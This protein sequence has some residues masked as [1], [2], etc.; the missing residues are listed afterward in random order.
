VKRLVD[1]GITTQQIVDIFSGENID[2]FGV[3]SASAQKGAGGL[4]SLRNALKDAGGTSEEVAR[5]MDDNLN[6]AI[7]N[8]QSAMEGFVIAVGEAGATDFLRGVLDQT[9]KSFQA[10]E[11][12]LKAV[13]A[14]TTN[15]DGTLTA[16]GVTLDIIIKVAAATAAVLAFELAMKGLAVA[17]GYVAI[18]A[19]VAWKAILSPLGLIGAGL[20]VGGALLEAFAQNFK[21]VR[22][23]ADALYGAIQGIVGGVLEMIGLKK[24]AE[25]EAT[26][27][28]V[29]ETTRLVNEYTA[30]MGRLGSASDETAKATLESFKQLKTPLQNLLDDQRQQLADLTKDREDAAARWV[31][32]NGAPIRGESGNLTNS[33]IGFEQTQ[34]DVDAQITAITGSVRKLE[35]TLSGSGLLEYQAQVGITFREN[36]KA[37]NAQ[38]KQQE[39][40]DAETQKAVDAVLLGLGERKRASA[41][42]LAQG[43]L[44]GQQLIQLNLLRET[45]EALRKAGIESEGAR[46]AILDGMLPTIEAIAVAENQRAE[47]NADKKIIDSLKGQNEEYRKLEE[48]VIR[49]R[50]ES[51]LTQGDVNAVLANSSYQ[52]GATELL[53]QL[54]P[55]EQAEAA[56]REALATNAALLAQFEQYLRDGTVKFADEQGVRNAIA[57]KLDQDLG[58]VLKAQKA[59]RDALDQSVGFGAAND[60]LLAGTLQQDLARIS[61]EEDTKRALLLEKY[62]T[63]VVDYQGYKDRLAAIDAE[64]GR[65]KKAAEIANAQVMLAAAQS[66]GESITGVLKET[67]GEQSVLY[68]ISFAAT[69]AFAIAQ[70]ILNIQTAL[71][72]AAASLPFPANLGAIATVAAETASIISTISSVALAMKD[73]GPVVGRGG[74]R[75]DMIP[76]MLSN[77]EFVI[78]AEAT[79]RNRAL[80]EAIN[81]NRRYADGGY[82]AMS[83]GGS[84][85]VYRGAGAAEV[86]VNNTF[87]IGAGASDTPE[88][89]RELLAQIDRQS[90]ASARM[91]IRE[92]MRANG[93][94][95]NVRG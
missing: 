41:A 74:P 45:D 60:P 53:S 93:M 79:K 48:R 19:G 81:G 32:L 33:G 44:E 87:N 61:L 47:N 91:A 57:A 25:L 20:A 55:K 78:N 65:R 11:G 63:G 16:L 75:D 23:V 71:S 92:E 12:A 6:G 13:S 22:A 35:A 69:K 84:G 66:T 31:E 58:A 95:A 10:F 5:I 67:L 26:N 39:A 76:A 43:D 88:R 73:G 38:R 50:D 40:L 42:L 64:S 62:N 68:K 80:L 49:L 56:K 37:A 15:T 1:A 72:S 77:G 18:A 30:A 52:K 82:V 83:T 8:A 51:K 9:A 36:E 70:S 7:L 59:E 17:F 94:L 89:Q 85:A 4:E 90:K 14:A 3:L 21:E 24:S 54:G 27:V 2:I 86:T 34:K 28:V 46:K 29:D